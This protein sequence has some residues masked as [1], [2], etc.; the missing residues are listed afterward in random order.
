M[1]SNRISATL[2]NCP[3]PL[4]II[5]DE[6]SPEEMQWFKANDLKIIE[7]NA[8]RDRAIA[9]TLQVQRQINQIQMS[10]I[11]LKAKYKLRD[12]FDKENLHQ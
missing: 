3:I 11:K 8:Q 2:N 10:I 1:S 6:N 4:V 9:E 5:P 12:N 7:L